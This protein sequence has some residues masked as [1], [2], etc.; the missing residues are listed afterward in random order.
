MTQDQ[1]NTRQEHEEQMLSDLLISAQEPQGNEEDI[2]ASFEIEAI[3]WS[4]DEAL[5]DPYEDQEPE[6]WLDF[7]IQQGAA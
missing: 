1:M 7:L 5:Y 6:H 2:I 3:E 4:F